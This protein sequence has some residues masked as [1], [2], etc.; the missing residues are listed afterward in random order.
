LNGT[1]CNPGNPVAG[2]QCAPDTDYSDGTSGQLL[3]PIPQ[4]CCGN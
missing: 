2:L 4:T 3:V 1:G